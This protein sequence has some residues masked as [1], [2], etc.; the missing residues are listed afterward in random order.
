MQSK[1]VIPLPLT[2]IF[3]LINLT[4]SGKE[5]RAGILV[6]ATRVRGQGAGHVL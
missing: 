2:F 1:R 4:F 3:S 6:S 5:V